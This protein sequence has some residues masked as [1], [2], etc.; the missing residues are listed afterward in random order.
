[1]GESHSGTAIATALEVFFQGF[2]KHW[3]HDTMDDMGGKVFVFCICFFVFFVL[4]G[5]T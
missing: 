2:S 4:V 3:G 5:M 1:V